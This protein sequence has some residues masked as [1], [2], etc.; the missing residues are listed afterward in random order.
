MQQSVPFLVWCA[1]RWEQLL[2]RMLQKN[3]RQRCAQNIYAHVTTRPN[4]ACTA[5]AGG[6][7][8]VSRQA[9]VVKRFMI[10]P[11][12]GE[13]PGSTPGRRTL[14]PIARPLL[15]RLGVSEGAGAAGAARPPARPPASQPRQPACPFQAPWG[16]PASQPITRPFLRRLGVSDGAPGLLWGWPPARPPATQPASQLR[17]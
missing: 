14:L 16:A 12:Q 9:P 10:S 7:K 13:G 6:D 11:F 2:G 4:A 1:V 15:R 5:T 8:E 3:G 17:L